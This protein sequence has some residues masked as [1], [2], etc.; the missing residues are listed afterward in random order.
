MPQ[1]NWISFI[2]NGHSLAGPSNTVGSNVVTNI[3][4]TATSDVL[5]SDSIGSLVLA[6]TVDVNTPSA[7]VS[8]SGSQVT[9]S[10]GLKFT[11]TTAHG[12][13]FGL[14][15]Q[16]T[17]STTLPTGISALTNYYVVPASATTYHVATSL[18]NAEAGTFVAYT[19]TG[20][21]NQTATPVAVSGASA[22]LQGTLD[23]QATWNT[24]PNST[25]TITADGSFLFELDYIRYGAYRVYI[26]MTTGMMAFTQLQIGWRD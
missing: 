2:D 16:Y 13:A 18:A 25:W 26:S 21:G 4:S 9:N 3:T 15:V 12:F 22:I 19:D 5:G 1:F 8:A 14:V 24:V 23:G 10:G 6:G 17:T 11:T 20:T 7:G